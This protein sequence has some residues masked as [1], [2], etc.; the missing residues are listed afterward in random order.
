M[1]SRLSFTVCHFLNFGKA[2]LE[3]YHTSVP[4]SL[5]LHLLGSAYLLSHGR[6][7][8]LC[9]RR[10]Y[11]PAPELYATRN[12]ELPANNKLSFDACQS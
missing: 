10:L 9:H 12:K 11:S 3:L 8:P 2:Y 1:H 6:F 5:L 4:V 7:G